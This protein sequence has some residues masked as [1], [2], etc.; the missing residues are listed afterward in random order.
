VKTRHIRPIIVTIIG[1]AIVV[2]FVWYLY[3]NVDKY[4]QLLNLSIPGLVMLFL[5]SLAFPVINGLMNTYMFRGL[6][7]NLSHREGFLLTAAATLANQLPLPAGMITRGVYLKRQYGLSYTG[8]FSSQLALFICIVA[9]DGF[10]GLGILLDW[11]FFKNASV[12]LVLPAAYGLMVASIFIFWLP[13]EHIRMPAAI[14][15]WTDQALE[16]WM[17]FKKK[18]VLLWK[19]L[20]LQTIE[21]LLLAIRYWLAFHMLSQNETVTQT[22]LF[23]TASILTQLVNILPG[24]LGVRE[25]LVGGVSSALGFDAGVSV[26]AVG[27][28]RLVS[29]VGIVLVGWI[30]TVLLGK[31]ISDVS[32]K[33]DEQEV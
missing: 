4:L 24:G 17:L 18:P 29:T 32:M 33:S 26:V 23:A 5:L 22:L 11:L 12:S 1:L 7:A 13:L 16:G 6:G 31:Q 25:A 3:K 9:I 30:S 27:L 14:R 15:K 28:D 2:G 8:Y 20:G 10:I 21:T 19:L